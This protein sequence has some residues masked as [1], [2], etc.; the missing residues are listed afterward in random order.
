MT[1]EEKA[2]ELFA[3]VRNCSQSVVLA[4]AEETGA[5]EKTL[6]AIAGGLG[7]GCSC[8]EICGA[9]SGAIMALGLYHPFTPE[10]GLE[11]KAYLKGLSARAVEEFRGEFG[12]IHCRDL[13]EKGGHEHCPALVAFAAK[14]VDK[15]N[16]EEAN[17]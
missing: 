4:F 16:L 17:K 3:T 15:I 14:T 5:D 6:T 12:C 8:G 13:L 10:N 11:A 7:G 1:H 2:K 9:L